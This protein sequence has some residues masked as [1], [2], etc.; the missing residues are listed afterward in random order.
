MEKITDS[1]G[2]AGALG[3]EKIAQT[4]AEKAT[5]EEGKNIVAKLVATGKRTTEKQIESV[6]E[7]G[8]KVVFRR[9]IGTHAHGLPGKYRGQGKIDHYNIE[10]QVPNLRGKFEVKENIH[11]ILDENFN[12]IDVLR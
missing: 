12:V 7:D 4:F 6:L 2:K 9:D 11:L 5:S 1:A 3:A 8:S 10:I